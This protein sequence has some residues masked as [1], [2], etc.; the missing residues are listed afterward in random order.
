MMPGMFLQARAALFGIAALVAFGGVVPLIAHFGAHLGPWTITTLLAIGI[1]LAARPAIAPESRV[2]PIPR[3]A[4]GRI[5]ASGIG[6]VLLG[7][8]ALAWGATHLAAGAIADTTIACGYALIVLDATVIGRIAGADPNAV[9]VVK[10]TLAIL[11]AVV[12]A[13]V[14]REAL[15]NA[16]NGVALVVGGAVCL[17]ASRRWFAAA[18]AG[19]GQASANPKPS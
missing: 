16:F 5:A 2:Q 1:A 4:F 19:L 7:P 9:T 3:T 15:P 14:T 6:G 8:S 11:I 18:R 13:I 10:S 12:L 17:G